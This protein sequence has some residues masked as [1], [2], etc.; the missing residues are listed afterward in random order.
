MNL[1][2]WTTRLAPWVKD[3]KA[4]H[5]EVCD[6]IGI[7]FRESFITGKP[8]EDLVLGPYLGDATEHTRIPISRGL[9]GMAVREERVINVS[10][11]RAESEH[12]A[13]SL[14]TRSE[15]VIPLKNSQGNIV[16]ELD[17]DCNQ[18]AAFTPSIEQKFKNYCEGFSAF[19]ERG[20]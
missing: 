1:Q 12:I 3:A 8:S 11:V 9:C 15:L 13:C 6:W 4:V 17:I 14:K 10:D 2:T 5:P 16:A 20:A 7:Y 18:L 19:L